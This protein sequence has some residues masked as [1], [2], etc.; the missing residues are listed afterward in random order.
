MG[1]VDRFGVL[2]DEGFAAVEQNLEPAARVVATEF[3]FQDWGG[4][5]LQAEKKDR[6]GRE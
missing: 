5:S 4:R 1:E 3:D 2:I 6:G